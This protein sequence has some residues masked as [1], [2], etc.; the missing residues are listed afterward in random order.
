MRAAVI[1][2]LT[3]RPGSVS[4]IGNLTRNEQQAANR[5]LRLASPALSTCRQ[6]S[7]GHRGVSARES[8]KPDQYSR[9]K[10]RRRGTIGYRRQRSV[11]Q[12]AAVPGS[13]RL[14]RLVDDSPQRS[15]RASSSRSTR[16]NCQ[17]QGRATV[18]TERGMSTG[19]GRGSTGNQQQLPTDA[20]G[21]LK[22]PGLRRTRWNGCARRRSSRDRLPALSG[23]RRL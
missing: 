8:P 10:E 15:R 13:Q 23:G 12:I 22:R 3:D 4:R 6:Y 19:C 21:P 16:S 20:W 7:G 2:G 9:Q 17:R 18:D 5:A 11:N 1:P 14:L